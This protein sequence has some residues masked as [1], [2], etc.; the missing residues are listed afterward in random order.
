MSDSKS[1]VPTK[2]IDFREQYSSVDDYYQNFKE[3]RNPSTISSG[4]SSRAPSSLIP[5]RR[6]AKCF[7]PKR[8]QDSTNVSVRTQSEPIISGRQDS[9]SEIKYRSLSTY[10]CK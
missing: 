4:T 1:S 9:E 7:E 5:D 2:I 3:N 10:S 6:K 8:L